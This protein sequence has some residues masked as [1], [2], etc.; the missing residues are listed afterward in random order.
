MRTMYCMGFSWMRSGVDSPEH[1][2]VARA[3]G[4]RHPAFPRRLGPGA[5]SVEPSKSCGFSS[6][7]A[8][9]GRGSP[10]MHLELRA[11]HL[12]IDSRLRELC[13]RHLLYSLG[14]FDDHI[15]RVQLWIEDVN[16]PRGGRD[17]RCRLR[18]CLRRGGAFSVA[19]LAER[20][21]AA[22]DEVFDR[23]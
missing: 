16:G 9:A 4:D 7:S 22:I 18:I 11:R 21:E 3:A 19:W 17:L 8:P 14:R 12:L 13:H 2:H 20:A 15:R 10:T 1:F 6:G 23:G 5:P